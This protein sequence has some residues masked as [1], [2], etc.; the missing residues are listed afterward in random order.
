MRSNVRSKTGSA[1]DRPAKPTPEQESPSA[2][3]WT[4]PAKR[5]QMSAIW[6]LMWLAVPLVGLVLYGLLTRH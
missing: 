3:D 6:P 2:E 1:A 5:H 4:D